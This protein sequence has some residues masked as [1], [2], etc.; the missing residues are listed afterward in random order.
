MSGQR[1]TTGMPTASLL[2]FRLCVVARRPCRN[3]GDEADQRKHQL[4]LEPLEGFGARAFAAQVSQ[5]L[6]QL[7][8]D[9]AHLPNEREDGCDH[10][11][12]PQ[13]GNHLFEPRTQLAQIRSERGGGCFAC[14]HSH[15]INRRPEE[16]I[17]NY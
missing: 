11:H 8:I 12:E 16:W 3:N 5:L 6:G 4:S 14:R 9:V 7:R 2:I 10:F 17:P 15:G 1:S 13:R